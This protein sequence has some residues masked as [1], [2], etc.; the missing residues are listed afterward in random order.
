MA[1][2]VKKMKAITS[3][4][5]NRSGFTLLEILLTILVLGVVV[6]LTLPRLTRK[7]P[8]TRW[9]NILEEVNNLGDVAGIV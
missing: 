3:I 5:E 9:E 8:S 7:D 6:T 1:L 4:K 2:M